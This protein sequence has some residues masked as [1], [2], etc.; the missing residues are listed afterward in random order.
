MKNPRHDARFDKYKTVLLR[1]ISPAEMRGLEIGALDLPFLT[2]DESD[3]EFADYA[4]T[5]ELRE[6][7]R[8][9]PGH[10]EEF[11]MP[12]N[13]VL[14]DGGWDSV[15]NQFDWIAAAHVIEHAPSLIDWLNIVGDKLKEGGILFLII[16]DKRYTFDFFRPET[17]LG[18]IFEDHIRGKKTP[19]IS[20]VF[21]EIFYARNLNTIDIWQNA[22]KIQFRAKDTKSVL[23][24]AKTVSNNYIDVHCNI[25]SN[26]SFSTVIST[27]CRDGWIPFIVEEIGTLEQFYSDFHCILRK[28]VRP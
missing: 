5:H 22:N 28:L 6:R 23:A 3:V 26:E 14:K 17:T 12:V 2:P 16:P 11:V 18:K 9:A 19:G 1:Y 7:A 10:S 4:T 25:F 20:E 21:D 27:L 15:P 24:V 8:A 13:F